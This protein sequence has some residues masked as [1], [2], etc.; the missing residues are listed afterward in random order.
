MIEYASQCN[1]Y[2]QDIAITIGCVT[3]RDDSFPVTSVPPGKENRYNVAG[4][5]T[6]YA[7]SGISTAK[8]EKY[9]SPNVSISQGDSAWQIPI[10]THRLLNLVE[11]LRDHPEDYEFYCGGKDEGSYPCCQG[12]RVL[13]ESQG[14]SGLVYPSYRDPGGICI[15]VWP[16]ED[17]GFPDPYFSKTDMK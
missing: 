11:Y 5:I 3:I 7:A 1:G 8:A 15:A 12:L 2:I 6:F 13:L 4:Q 17:H 9:G 10:G 14:C 16:I